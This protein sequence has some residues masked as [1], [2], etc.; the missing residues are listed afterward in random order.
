MQL[1]Q[2]D[3]FKNSVSEFIPE[4]RIFTDELRTLAYGTDASFYRLIPKLV[5]KV[6]NDTEVQRLIRTADEFEIPLTFRA[7]G[8]SLSGQSITDSVLVVIEDSWKNFKIL[9]NGSQISLQPGVI[10]AQANLALLSYNKKMGPDPA[11][12]DHAK[13]A[14]IAANNA[15]GMTSGTKNNIYNTLSGMKIIFSDGSILDTNSEM[16]KEIFKETNGKLYEA[17]AGLSTKVKS[18]IKLAER[19][20]EK[21]RMKNTTGYSLNALVDFD[22]PFQIIP[23]LMIGSEGTLGFISEIKLNTVP[24]Y[25]HKGTALILFKNIKTACKAIP[26]FQK[27]TVDA[28]EI[29]DRA[30]LRSVENKPGMPEHLKSLSEETAAL[31]IETSS[32]DPTLLQ[33]QIK[34]ISR[35]L[36]HLEKEFPIEF[37]TDPKEYKM[38]WDVRNGLFPS[39]C[40]ARKAGTTVIIEDVNF[41]IDRLS[42]AVLDLQKLFDKHHYH[43]TII[44][45]HSLAGNIHFVFAVDFKSEHE[46]TRY[47]DFM[48]DITRLVVEKYDGSL[49]AEH[50][51]GRNMA[52]FVEYEWGAEAYEVMREIKNIFDPLNILNPG[53]LINDDKQV[54]LKNLKPTPIAD[55]LIDKCIECGFCE[56]SCPSKNI[57]LTPRQRITSWREIIE[58]RN[59]GKDPE[60]QETLTNSFDY[61]G[62]QTCATDGLCALSCPVD[63]DTGDLIKHLRTENL[64][65]S[66]SSIASVI[67]HHISFV[68]AIGRFGLNIVHFYHLILGEKFMT[69]VS[70]F[71][72]KMFGKNFPLWN[73][74]MPKGADKILGDVVTAGNEFKVVYFPSCISRTMGNPKN[75]IS[76]KSQT[77]VTHDLLVKAGYDVLYPN[78]L[79]NLCCG[80][81]FS[82]KGFKNEGREKADE[83]ISTLKVTSENGKY[84]ILF[85]T[86]PCLQTIKKHIQNGNNNSLKLYEPVEFINDFLLKK[87]KINKKKDTIT[88]HVTC[89]STKMGLDDKFLNVAKACAENVIVPK[90]VGCCGFA[91]DRGFSYPE[92]T[93]SAL[94]ELKPQLTDNCKEGYSNSKT[95]EIGL[96]LHS[97]IEYRSIVYLVDECT[98]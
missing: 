19:I 23:H 81:A 4:K 53:V 58:L 75:S 3:N 30:A 29:M 52:P 25:P 26:V 46:V 96:S 13:I 86:S 78:N 7:A 12:I 9:N 33:N 18:N 61:Y 72:K 98:N 51:T 95:C 60:R 44:F 48:D 45:G 88:I 63:I 21:Y 39:V 65:P 93:E 28:A 71:K 36:E 56:V 69:S 38:L 83:L 57:T 91:G 24:E 20:T 80:M 73:K 22:D 8:T 37:T 77:T 50:G 31:L 6:E 43:N 42:D 97:G 32:N 11:S 16:S 49:K 67:A 10:G 66:T 17:I 47:K 59:N 85:D 90:E 70:R 55:D 84:P 64:K 27:L 94:K 89:S 14:G 54:H 62:N 34:E 74:Y 76:K 5:I 41:P 82:S 92:L 68:T 2:Y 1:D 79:S 40:A 35:S 87:I 15:S